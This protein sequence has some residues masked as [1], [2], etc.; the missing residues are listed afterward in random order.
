MTAKDILKDAENFIAQLYENK[1]CVAVADIDHDGDLDIFVGNLTSTTGT[2]FGMPQTSHLYLN[3]GK[4]HFTIA[5][6]VLI[7]IK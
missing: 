5:L 6:N 4:G 7:W 3:D 2:A 1:S